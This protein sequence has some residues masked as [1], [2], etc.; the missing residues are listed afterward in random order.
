ME[1]SAKELGA[2]VRNLDKTRPITSATNGVNPNNKVITEDDLDLVGTNYDLTKIPELAK[3]FP[4]RPIIGAETTSSLDIRGPY[5]LPSDEILRWPRKW[6]RQ[7]LRRKPDLRCSSYDNST[8]PWGAH[9]KKHGKSSRTTDFFSGMF[10][11]TGWD[12]IGEPTPFPWPAV[13]S[14]FGIIDLAGFPK[15]ALCLYQSEWTNK[16]VLHYF[17]IGMETGPAGRRGHIFQQCR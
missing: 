13:S 6:R 17:R 1:Q 5:E 8:A 16:P 2:I 3:M 7:F 10:I 9:T 14:Y 11:W 4:G 15:D 12:Y